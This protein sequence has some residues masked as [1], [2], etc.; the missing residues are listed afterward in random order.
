M[1]IRIDFVTNSSSSSYLIA[2]KTGEDKNTVSSKK[3]QKVMNAI[4]NA[5]GCDTSKAITCNN[6]EEFEKFILERYSVESLE[7]L[8]SEGE[9]MKN[10]VDKAKKYLE[11]GY[12]LAHKNIGYDDDV[13]CEIISSLEDED[14]I[15]LEND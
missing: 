11:E 1:K 2:Y 6:K 12:I 3:I 5:T 4:F 14:F 8:Y 9:Y 15:I 7:E 10:Y 13:L